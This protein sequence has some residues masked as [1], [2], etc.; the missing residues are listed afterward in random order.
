MKHRGVSLVI[1]ADGCI[2][3]ALADHLVCAGEMVLQTT[4][5][6]NTLSEKRVFLDLGQDI[7]DWSPPCSVSV[8]YLCAG[9]SSLDVCRKAPEQSAIVNV[10][11][12]LTLA[13]TLVARGIFVIFPSTDLVFNGSG[14]FREADDPV[15]PLT[16]YG[17]QKAEA[18]R[19]LLALGHL[20]SVVRFTKVLGP[21]MPLFKQWMQA[22][23]NHEVIH[24]FSDLILAPIPLSFAIQV[25]YR[26]GEKRLPGIC[27]V[28]GEQDITYEQAARYI[29]Q[30]LGVSLDLV[31]PV[32]SEEMGLQLEAI[33]S[34]SALDMARLRAEFEM[35]PPNVWLTIDA[36]LG[37]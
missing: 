8:A 26:I 30:R 4:R 33:R 13:R 22:L 1:G 21:N 3:K 5:R 34:Y 24:P 20:I 7:S 36:T 2:G 31:Q 19:Q 32:K 16:E 14:P 10:H 29:A 35:Q 9:V 28:S 17:R 11:N 6:G 37:L 25:L 23:R 15:Y 18:E 12:T 27:Q